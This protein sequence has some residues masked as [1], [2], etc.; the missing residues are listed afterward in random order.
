MGKHDE[1]RK[2]KKKMGKTKNPLGGERVQGELLF[3]K[4]RSK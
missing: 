1:V 2:S 3:H 4:A